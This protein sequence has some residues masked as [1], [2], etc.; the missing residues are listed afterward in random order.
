LSDLPKISRDERLQGPKP[1]SRIARTVILCGTALISLGSVVAPRAKANV[2]AQS[3]TVVRIAP[4]AGVASP[5][6]LILTPAEGADPIAQHRS[7]SSHASHAS[8]Y[9]S[10]GGSLPRATA[11]PAAKSPA[12]TPEKANDGKAGVSVSS[13]PALADIEVDGKFMGST[14]STLR[15]SPGAHNLTIRKSGYEAWTR[16]IEVTAGSDLAVHADLHAN[17]PAAPK[18]A[19]PQKK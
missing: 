9:S 15:L 16:S 10:S 12:T 8:H 7:H 13:V 14:R 1:P 4:S 19:S 6:P 17:R 18:K 3:T 5:S 2:P 11:P